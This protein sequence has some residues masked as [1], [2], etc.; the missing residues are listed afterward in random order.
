MF[1]RFFC[2]IQSNAV[3]LKIMFLGT[4]MGTF[5]KVSIFQVPIFCLKSTHMAKLITPL[6]PKQIDNA[7]PK[8]RAF[9]PFFHT[10]I[11]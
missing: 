1:A 8:D 5:L 9:I 7:K 3:L 11:V 4:V 6:A 2:I 10:W